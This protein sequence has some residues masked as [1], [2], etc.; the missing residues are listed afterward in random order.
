MSNERKKQL[1]ENDLK[2]SSKLREVMN[3][4]NITREK[5]AEK[6]GINLSA[7]NT[8]LSNNNPALPSVAVASRIAKALDKSLDYLTGINK[9]R[10]IKPDKNI[11]PT[12]LLKNLARVIKDTNLKIELN[13]QNNTSILSS[14]NV[15]IYTFLSQLN[16]IANNLNQEDYEANVND[17]VQGYKSLM[18]DNGNLIDEYTYMIKNEWYYLYKGLDYSDNGRSEYPEEYAELELERKEKWRK[19]KIT[20]DFSFF[21]SL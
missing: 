6:S 10:E 12:V 1:D 11:T 18:I 19:A 8:Y 3:D 14:N 2:F 7:L 13:N 15:N 9:S 16:N 4:N 20:K 21:K 5:L 17:I